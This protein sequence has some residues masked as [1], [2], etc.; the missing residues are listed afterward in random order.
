MKV[1]NPNLDLQLF[2][3]HITQAAY[4]VLF[5]DYDGTLA[6]FN[7]E[8]AKALPYPGIR[9]LLNK[10]MLSGNVRLVII[11]GRWIRDLI[12]L[13]KL[14]SSPEIWGSH[15][16]ERLKPDGSYEIAP[17]DETALNG[18]VI[19]HEWVESMGLAAH[20]EEKPG[21]LALH[22]RGLDSVRAQEIRRIVQPKWELIAE[23]WKLRLSEF[24]GGLELRVPIR[25]KGYA[26]RTVLSEMGGDIAAAYLGDDKTDE[27]AFKS[28][29]G[30]GIGVLVRKEMRDTVADMWIKPPREL[31]DFLSRWLCG[32]MVNR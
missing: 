23:G 29:K 27:D 1:L 24:D 6:P 12:P 7:T 16:L 8:P 28:I 10:I 19:A 9:D 25:D 5:L 26:V 18:L 4:R 32:G 13:L 11:T 30:R 22:W 3:Q 21:C 15:G 14:N 2:Y 20:C 17:M 31:L